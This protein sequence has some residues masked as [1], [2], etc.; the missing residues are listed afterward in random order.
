[1]HNDKSES[2]NETLILIN[3][4]LFILRWNSLCSSFH[5][6]RRQ[7]LL[8]KCPI[9]K[10]CHVADRSDHEYL[11]SIKTND[12]LGLCIIH[13]DQYSVIQKMS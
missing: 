13:T 12:I 5:G 10:D 9:N 4:G 8:L 1:M 11:Y 3:R 7:T 6:N 2:L